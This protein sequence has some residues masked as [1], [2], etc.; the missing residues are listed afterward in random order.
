VPATASGNPSCRWARRAVPRVADLERHAVKSGRRH[1]RRDIVGRWHSPCCL[2]VCVARPDPRRRERDR[3]AGCL[4]LPRG[5]EA[6]DAGEGEPGMRRRRS[7]GA[8]ERV[9]LRGRG[10]G[11]DVLHVHVLLRDRAV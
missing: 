2:R 10:G 6:Q 8:G 5:K 7:R 1:A 3:S 9:A 11:G 4:V